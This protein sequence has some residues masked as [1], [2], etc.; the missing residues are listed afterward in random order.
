VQPQIELALEQDIEE[1]HLANSSKQGQPVHIA[2]P[3]HAVSTVRLVSVIQS[4][5]LH[6][7]EFSSPIDLQVTH[8]SLVLVAWKILAPRMFIDTIVMVFLMQE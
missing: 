4:D 1:K 2:S 7:R 8:V 3:E 6:V 5:K